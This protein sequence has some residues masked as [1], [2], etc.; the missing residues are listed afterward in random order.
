MRSSLLLHSVSTTGSADRRMERVSIVAISICTIVYIGPHRRPPERSCGMD[1]FLF[2]RF[3]PFVFGSKISVPHTLSTID[4]W[5]TSRQLE[6]SFI[7]VRLTQLP[8][9]R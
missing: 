5:S 3:V 7:E 6:K 2:P 8:K 4:S 9:R 1:T